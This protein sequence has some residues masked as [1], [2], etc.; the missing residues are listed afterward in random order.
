[1]SYMSKLYRLPA[2]ICLA[3][4][5]SV[6]TASVSFAQQE[7]SPEHLATARQYVDMSDRSNVYELA[8][9][10]LGMAVMRTLVQQD[11]A[12][13]EPLPDAVQKVVEEY[14]ARKGEL[15]NQF[16]RIYASR[17]THEELTEIVTFYESDVGQKLLAQNPGINNDMQNVLNIWEQN[18]RT[19]FLSRV[20]AVLR[21]EGYDV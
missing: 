1:M 5:I 19:E 11:A 10:E 9:I 12:L 4:A 21:E 13:V 2:A 18:A 7:I 20:R 6:S 16:A 3:A 17:F 15:Y 8:L 14:S